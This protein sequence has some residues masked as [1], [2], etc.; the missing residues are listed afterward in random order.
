M[1]PL[2]ETITPNFLS[3]FFANHVFIHLFFNFVVVSILAV[4]LTFVARK[5]VDV[6]IK[7]T[8]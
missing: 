7:F 1:Q 6:I 5:T 4:L 3:D 2:F 8:V